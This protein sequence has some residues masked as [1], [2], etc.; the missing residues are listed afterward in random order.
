MRIAMLLLGLLI[1]FS[2]FADDGMWMPHQIA[3]LDLGEQGFECDP[4]MLFRSDGRG[5]MNA[6]VKL[7]GATGAFVSPDGLIL[8]NHHVA[9]RAIQRAS[10]AQ[11][12][13]L[14]DGLVATRAEEIQA[15]G[16][17]AYVLLGYEDVTAEI[18]AAVKD[19]M[20]YRQKYDAIDKA[21]KKL[22][23]RAEQADA[24][25]R[26]EVADIYSGHYYY[27]FRYKRLLD[28][29][30]VLAPPED[31]G[32]FGGEIDNWMWPRHTCDFTFLR[33][34]VATDG[35][36]AAY[37]PENVPYQPTS[38]LK[39]A[40][41]GNKNDDLNFVMGYPGRT[42][43]NDT[44][45]EM[46][47]AIDYMA[48]RSTLY[49]ELMAFFE[50]AADSR[51]IEIK[52]AGT[53]RGLA[54]AHK[55]YQ[56]KMA[57]FV[58]H[59]VLAKIRQ[60]EEAFLTWAGQNQADAEAGRYERFLDDYQAAQNERRGLESLV[61]GYS[62][63]PVLLSQ[64]YTIYR[65]VKEREK[66]DIEREAGY[67]ERNLIDI[68][69]RIELADRSYDVAVDRAFF[70]YLLVRMFDANPARVPI[71][72]QQVVASKSEATVSDFVDALYDA[73]R[74]QTAAE[75]L[76]LLELNLKELRAISDPLLELAA[77]IE[78][79]LEEVRERDKALNQ[80]KMELKEAVMAGMLRFDRMAPD[81]NST[82][83]LAFGR[84]AGYS[85]RDAVFYTPF[86]TLTGLL[87]KDA[88]Q[89]PFIVPEKMKELIAARDFGPYVDSE[90][91]DVVT[92]LLNTTNTTGGNS[93][94]PT[95]NA[96][97]EIIGILFDGT[98]ESVIGD[99]HYI[100]EL[101][102]S[103]SVDIRYVLFVVEK[104]CGATWLLE[105]LGMR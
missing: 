68:R 105:E 13:Y 77:N 39:I 16:Q 9:Y 91:G 78:E 14:K 6:V 79:Q 44:A 63:V 3:D 23:K 56:A 17:M 73:T 40:L 81:A 42:Y 22:V 5:L 74:L 72:L 87:E 1:G 10:D 70:K 65:T 48:E 25:S 94:S 59:D 92:C 45:K 64:A 95:L 66:P 75:R 53:L 52:Y 29:R 34:Y 12:D 96:K 62:A 54:N 26:A 97:G 20:T 2:L 76:K 60:R 102:R 15:L 11:H 101:Q 32:R 89:E 18:K 4:D 100:P 103:I 80:E 28:I 58:Q 67:Q 84:V 93:G 61:S 36:G 50:K 104:Y 86:T 41:D 85:P 99:Y 47:Q 8:T 43:R 38:F 98:Y 88:G 55:N 51:D 46:Q 90:I 19:K 35:T 31:L 21:K 27:L 37:S 49:T 7:S 83:R 57:G 69:Q 30:I 82:L 24:D 71:A 33:A